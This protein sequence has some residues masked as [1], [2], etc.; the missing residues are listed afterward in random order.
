MF[1]N[2][3]TLNLTTDIVVTRRNQDKYS[4]EYKYISSTE[5]VTLY[6]R[7]SETLQKDGRVFKSFNLMVE[8]KVYATLTVPERINTASVTTRFEPGSSLTAVSEYSTAL[9]EQATALM[10][11]L[12]QG[13]C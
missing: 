4:S 10:A 13:D 7:Q 12:I 5:E 11:G 9:Y 3:L 2:T 8:H 1:A 6:I